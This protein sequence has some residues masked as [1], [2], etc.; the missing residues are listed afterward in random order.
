MA[1]LSE[2]LPDTRL[3]YVADRESDIVELTRTAH[4]LVEPMGWLVRSQHNRALR[5]GDTLCGPRSW[6]ASRWVSH[7]LRSPHAMARTR[8][9]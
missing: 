8:G 5:K 2:S 7:V 4:E 3:I 6:P 9:R 1:E